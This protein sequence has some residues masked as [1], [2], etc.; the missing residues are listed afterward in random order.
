M[1]RWLPV[2]ANQ[3]HLVEMHALMNSQ[4]AQE[5]NL[6]KNRPINLWHCSLLMELLIGDGNHSLIFCAFVAG[7]GK[8][9]HICMLFEFLFYILENK[10]LFCLL[11]FQFCYQVS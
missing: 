6:S 11:S 7:L 10:N 8:S 1:P 9:D 2:Q 5:T 3:W 4:Q